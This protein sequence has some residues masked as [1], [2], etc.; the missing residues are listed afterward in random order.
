MTSGRQRPTAIGQPKVNH[1]KDVENLAIA[2]LVLGCPPKNAGNSRRNSSRSSGTFGIRDTGLGASAL[3]GPDGGQSE[4]A[5]FD[6]R[7]WI[8]VGK[9][10]TLFP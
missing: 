6:G 3:G 10:P 1:S 7:R 2:T 4:V 9:P 5:G 8:V